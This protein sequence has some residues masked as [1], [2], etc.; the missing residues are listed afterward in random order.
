[1]VE[2]DGFDFIDGGMGGDILIGG[3]GGDRFYHAGVASH[4]SDWVLDYTAAQG[5][6]L[7]LGL[8]GVSRNQITVVFSSSNKLDESPAVGDA[9]VSHIPT[10]RALWM[11]V[12][13][14]GQSQIKVVISNVVYDLLA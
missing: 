5:D 7:H 11:L 4:S 10:N 2:G 3:T 9:F 8:A 13:G 12:D 14:A 6:V 1:M